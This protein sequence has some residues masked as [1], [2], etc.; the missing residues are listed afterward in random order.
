MKTLGLSRVASPRGQ[1][2]FLSFFLSSSSSFL[3][4]IAATAVSFD[5]CIES[6]INICRREYYWVLLWGSLARRLNDVGVFQT[7]FDLREGILLHLITDKNRGWRGTRVYVNQQLWPQKKQSSIGLQQLDDLFIICHPSSKW[8]GNTG[9]CV[10]RPQN[11]T[12]HNGNSSEYCF[13][14]ST[15]VSITSM[16]LGAPDIWRNRN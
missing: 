9:C 13:R 7:N 1:H 11:P 12:S 10:T 8:A 14:F 5:A 16:Q 6:C 4:L 2:R 3:T 15:L